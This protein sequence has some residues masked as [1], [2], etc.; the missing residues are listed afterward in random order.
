MPVD[1]TTLQHCV[2]ALSIHI[3]LH[4]PT[5]TGVATLAAEGDMGTNYHDQFHYLYYGKL[6]L[7][8]INIW[9]VNY[10]Q[11]NKMYLPR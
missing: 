4:K 3:C 2:K 9:Q 6:N 7:I 5:N 8:F 10:F 11:N 1:T